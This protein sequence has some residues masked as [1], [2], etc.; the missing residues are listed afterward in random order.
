M[1]RVRVTE[2]VWAEFRS[3]AADR[4]LSLV[5]GELVEREVRQHR[6]RRIRDRSVDDAEVLEALDRAEQLHG[7]LSA[8]VEW[9]RR[10]S[11]DR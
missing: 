10:R 2:E 8:M 4:P 1:A 3:L 7:E 5:L 9:L 6:E 11:R